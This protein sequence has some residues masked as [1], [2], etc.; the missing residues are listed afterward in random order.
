MKQYI[1]T[2]FCIALPLL[3]SSCRE[4]ETIF[5][6]ENEQ[7]TSPVENGEMMGFFLLNEGNM[8]MNLATIDYF[9]YPTGTYFRDIYSEKNPT[10]VKELGDVGNDM[11]MYGNKLYAVIN[12]S[13]KIEVMNVHTAKRITDI[14]VPNCRYLAFNKDKAYISS[15]AGQVAI[16][17]NAGPGF[18]AEIDTT[19]LE[20]TRK[21]TVG[22]Q[23]EEMVVS[24]GKLYVA[25]SGGYRAPNYDKT[26]SVIDLNTFEI[27]KTID[28]DINLHRMQIDK[29]GDIYVSSRGNYDNI[30][31][32]LYVIDSN[33]DKL[34][35]RLDIPIGD[36]YL[37]GDSL[38][39]YSTTSASPGN[40]AATYGI[41]DTQTKNIITNNFITDGT[42]K[43]IM[44]P[45][46]LA[47]NPETREI[48][49]TDAQNYVVSGYIYC[50]SS[51]GKIKWKTMTGNIPAHITFVP[52][53]K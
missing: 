23:P 30:P 45:Y 29:R 42:D 14:S 22:Y 28:V 8:G 43:N 25:N 52:K 1:V 16:D 32:R 44:M 31:S 11:K 7:I 20:V 33:T 3:V 4:D 48:Y 53:N 39:F 9:E 13:N 49:V 26:V 40:S 34:K 17:P 5:L 18:V 2:L 19:T 51:N 50:F 6:T 21:I 36:M 35:Q 38:Y 15:Y 12:Y 47:V 46:G 27:L 37:C 24:N 10:V 41:L